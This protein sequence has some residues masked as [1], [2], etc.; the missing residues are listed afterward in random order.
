[1]V[2]NE[3]RKYLVILLNLCLL[4]I[5]AFPV[6]SFSSIEATLSP[7]HTYQGYPAIYKNTVVWQDYRNGNYDIF[8]YDLDTRSEYQITSEPHDQVAPSIYGNKIVWEDHRNGG[9][10]N[11][12][13]YMYNLS[14]GE[15]GVICDESHW[16]GNPVIWENKIFWMD[17]RSGLYNPDIYMY[18]LDKEKEIPLVT[19]SSDQGKPSVYGNN[20]VFMDMRLGNRDIWMK[21]LVSGAETPIYTNPAAQL[22]PSIWGNKVV[23]EDQRSGESDIYLKNLATGREFPICRAPGDQVSPVISGD[24]V[25]WEDYRGG[26]NEADIYG[27]EINLDGSPKNEFSVTENPAC[28]LR[29]AIYEDKAVYQDDRTGEENI[30]IANVGKR[31]LRLAGQ[32]RYETSIALSQQGWQDSPY[33]ILARGDNFPDALAGAPLAAKYKAPILLTSPKWLNI[34]VA[35]EISRLKAKEVIILGAVGAVSEQVELDLNSRCGISNEKIHRIGGASRYDTAGKIA[36]WLDKPANKTAIIATGEDFPDVLSVASMAAAKDM[37]ILLVSISNV[38][39]AVQD[40]LKSLGIEKTIIVGGN[41]VVP[42]GIANWLDNQGYSSQRLAGEDRYE[43]SKMIADYAVSEMD[44]NPKK[45][46]V[47]T[48]EN[49]PD[50]LVAGALAGR[51]DYQA[52]IIISHSSSLPPS[53]QDWLGKEKF[54]I[55][56]LYYMGDKTVVYEVVQM[57]IEKTIL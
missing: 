50:A 27:C 35:E 13:I 26:V 10:W 32:S 44:L 12:D 6:I 22:S 48:G 2:K 1:M 42:D 17:T 43:T 7:Y 19:N 14:T 15:E 36:T 39:A 52:P 34:N 47:A 33:V 11:G 54:N 16:Q 25:I 51:E 40:A 37:P 8:A 31:S 5:L 28:Q 41:D 49:F 57:A 23:W 53:I 18:D 4:G 21:S 56:V 9:W 24:Y 45:I 29:P 30:Y 3:I 20:M 46:F 38:S 55:R